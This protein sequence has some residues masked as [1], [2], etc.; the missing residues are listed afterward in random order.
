MSKI[1]ILSPVY[2]AE[3]IV[4]HLVR[5][6]FNSMQGLTESF[7][8]LLVEDRSRNHSWEAIERNAKRV[9]K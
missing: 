6:I 7:E 5:K 2:Q 4:P 8:V 9:I 3:E 1:S